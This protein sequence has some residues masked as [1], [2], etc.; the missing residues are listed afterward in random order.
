MSIAVEAG[1]TALAVFSLILIL[2]LLSAVRAMRSTESIPMVLLGAGILSSTVG[3]AVANL[4]CNVQLT[5]QIATTYWL[6]AGLLVVL[7]QLGRGL[8]AAMENADG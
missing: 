2:T 7:P 1:F 3:L 5:E 6:L 4:G 8:S